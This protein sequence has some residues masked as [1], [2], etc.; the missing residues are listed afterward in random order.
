[1]K[2][3]LMIL[4]LTMLATMNMQASMSK[5]VP[6]FKALTQKVCQ[7]LQ[8]K[9][10]DDC[11]HLVCDDQISEDHFKNIDECTSA[12][13][14]A[15]YAQG[16]CENQSTLEDLVAAYNKKHPNSKIKCD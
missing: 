3:I 16:Y 10:D 7:A 12:S 4:T 13:D 15:E 8:T 14:Y 1:M 6:T 11:A 2:K 9:V 5:A